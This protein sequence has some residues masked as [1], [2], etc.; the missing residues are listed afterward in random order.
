MS[1][2][3]IVLA[4]YSEKGRGDIVLGHFQTYEGSLKC[5]RELQDYR[6]VLGD[7]VFSGGA[8]YTVPDEPYPKDHFLFTGLLPH[9]NSIKPKRR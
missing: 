8:V 3:Y 2:T 9:Y 6:N 4:H 5:L 7:G 1:D